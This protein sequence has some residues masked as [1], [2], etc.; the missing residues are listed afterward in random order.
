MASRRPRRVGEL[1][2]RELG[3]L[4]S[5]GR[6]KDPDIG[7]VTFTGVEM[8]PDLR[9]ARAY[10]SVMGE[11][12]SVEQTQKA[13]TRVVPWVRRELGRRL[14]LRVVPN[15]EFRLD[16]TLAQ[17]ARIDQLL[18]EV[19]PAQPATARADFE[20]DLVT[21]DGEGDDEGAGEVLD[22]LDDDTQDED[23]R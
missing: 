9:E 18:H 11:S 13:M 23:G 17:A 20:M 12:V 22:T 21:E 19:R 4:F 5:Q 2:L 8:S 3:E 15:V 1:I 7:F 6:V 16:K 14:Q 10:Y